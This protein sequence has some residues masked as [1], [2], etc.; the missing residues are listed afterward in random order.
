MSARDSVS[1]RDSA[2]AEHARF[3]LTAL[4]DKTT[5]QI[6]FKDRGSRFIRISTTLALKLG[7]AGPE[8]VIGKTDFDF[9]SEEHA[10][11]AFDDE[12]RIIQSGEPI[13]GIEER[14][15]W[16][17]G[18]EAWVMTSKAPLRDERGAVIGTF[19][20]SRDVTVE[21]A[22]RH[23]I[24]RQADLLRRALADAGKARQNL[25]TALGELQVAQEER[26]RLLARTVE[27]AEQ[28]R[29][30]IAADLHDGP[31]QRLTAIAFTID[32]L[33]N[34]LARSEQNVEGLAQKARD[35]LAE[36]IASLRRMFSE[37]LPPILDERGVAAAISAAAAELL[38][39]E[40][41]YT[42]NDHTDG[43][44]FAHD[45]E[46]A[47]YRIAR[48]AL[49]NVQEHAHPTHVEVDLDHVGGTL[50]LTVADDG[51]GF[52]TEGPTPNTDHAGL[53]SMRERAESLA[54]E[55][56]VDFSPGT[57]TRVH[58]TV[59]WRPRPAATP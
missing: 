35:E 57:G 20:I 19:G 48:E 43:I 47:A 51:V 56:D 13:V 46:T 4:L 30:R 53:Q 41:T 3:L 44:R 58:A 55:L 36:E 18:R 5:D 12:Q 25:Q 38:P 37:L 10:R 42:V 29:R 24:D 16:E 39:P 7:L 59:P 45:V 50:R 26:L 40:T 17:N 31:V 21:T 23:E 6:Y 33:V 11:Q 49:V 2:D 15:T 32:L 14:E 28:E 34:R 22:Q 1:A 9:F 54:G 27:V 8:E 52:D